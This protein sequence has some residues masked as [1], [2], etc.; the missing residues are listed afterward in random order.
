MDRGPATIDEPVGMDAGAEPPGT[1]PASH[2]VRP[3]HIAFHWRHS[4]F[5]APPVTTFQRTTEVI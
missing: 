1:D 5:G 3:D 2:P 4:P